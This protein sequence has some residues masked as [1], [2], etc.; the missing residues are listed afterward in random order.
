MTSIL[1]YKTTLLSRQTLIKFV[2][3]FVQSF[4]TL[5]IAL[6]VLDILFP[7]T[8]GLKYHGL[9]TFTTASL[10]WAVIS[11]HPRFEISRRLLV[12]DTIIKIKVGDLF[13]EDADLIIGMNDTFD[14]EKGNIIKAKSIQGQFLATVYNDDTS[15]LNTDLTTALNGISGTRDSQKSQG[16]KT[17]YPIGTVATLTAGTKKYYCSAYSY[18][19]NDLKAQS[20]IKKLSTSLDMLWGE[21]RLKGQRGKVAMAVLGSDLA[22]IGTASHSN[23]IKLIVSSFLL[24]SRESPISEQLTI[25]VYPSNLEKVNMLELNDFLQNF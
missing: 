2:T 8:L 18:M 14:T 9:V 15:R 20:D 25:V 10:V 4:G 7:N 16:K 6:G 23:L 17:R 19:G 13:K 12:P 1:A 5:A 3:A 21:I 22:R 24:A 11:I